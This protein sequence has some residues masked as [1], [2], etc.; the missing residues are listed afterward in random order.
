MEPHGVSMDCD[1]SSTMCHHPHNISSHL[2]GHQ[3]YRAGLSFATS[4]GLPQ[5]SSPAHAGLLAE[6][7]QPSA[8]VRTD[9]QHVGQNDSKSQQLEGYGTS[10]IW[11]R[12][13]IPSAHPLRCIARS[14]ANPP[15]FTHRAESWAGCYC[16]TID[17]QRSGS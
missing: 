5:R 3:C 17:M 14:D 7:P 8:K 12:A 11:V 1:L 16:G 10:V 9:S 4:Y 15:L 6:G 2:A 13:V